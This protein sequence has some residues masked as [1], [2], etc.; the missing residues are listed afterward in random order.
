MFWIPS[1]RDL[2]SE[3]LK[4]SHNI[5]SAINSSGVWTLKL[6]LKGSSWVILWPH[7]NNL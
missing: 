3:V 2:L 4:E 6:L 1:K 7:E 5:D